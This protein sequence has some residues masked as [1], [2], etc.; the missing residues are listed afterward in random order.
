MVAFEGL[1][2]TAPKIFLRLFS[3]GCFCFVVFAW[4]VVFASLFSLGWLF[5]LRCFRLVGC[6]YEGNLTR[7]RTAQ[8]F[9]FDRAQTVKQYCRVLT[10]TRFQN[11]STDVLF[12]CEG[13]IELSRFFGR[14][15]TCM[16]QS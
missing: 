10:Q 15:P 7:S 6:F 13:A 16:I 3:D 14:S 2:T 12:T 1:C 9:K 4:L 5:L 8:K 11:T